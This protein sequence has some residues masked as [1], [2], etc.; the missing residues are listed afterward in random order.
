VSGAV[1]TQSRRWP[2][3]GVA[4]PTRELSN[5]CETTSQQKSPEFS[6]SALRS[7]AGTAR[8]SDGSTPVAMFP[9]DNSNKQTTKSEIDAY[10]NHGEDWRHRGQDLFMRSTGLSEAC[11]PV[12]HTRQQVSQPNYTVE[13]SCN[14]AVDLEA[15]CVSLH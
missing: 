15:T 8:Y 12:R 6:P 10:L 3:P 9:G 2:V 5:G 4:Y 11:G 7:H 13:N 14:V 1:R